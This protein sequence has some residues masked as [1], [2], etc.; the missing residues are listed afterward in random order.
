MMLRRNNGGRNNFRLWRRNERNNTS[1]EE[2]INEDNDS[3]DP[4]DLLKK[5]WKRI[6]PPTPEDEV[7]KGWYGAIYQEKKNL[8]CTLGKLLGDFCWA[9]MG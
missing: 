8:I 3:D 7:R 5:V 2:K 6:S 9:K 4:A 1:D